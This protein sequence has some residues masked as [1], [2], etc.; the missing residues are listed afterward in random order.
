MK[1]P[2]TKQL[3]EDV[4]G[5]YYVDADKALPLDPRLVQLAV[6]RKLK[7]SVD[8]M[9]GTRRT[10]DIVLARQLAMYLSREL[11]SAS[12]P[13]IGRAFGGKDH[14]T[15]LHSIHKIQKLIETDGTIKQF[16]ADITTELK[17]GTGNG[18]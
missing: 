14:T 8:D 11:T 17:N 3:A 6:S 7:V 15:V 1:A 5:S 12:L 16:T 4:L 18:A 13:C 9:V 2:I 10:Q